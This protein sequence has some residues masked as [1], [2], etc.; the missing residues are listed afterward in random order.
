MIL[1][2]DKFD[3]LVQ[4]LIGLEVTRVWRGFGTALFIELGKLSKKSYRLKNGK[5]NSFLVGQYSIFIG[6][7]W[8]VE[9]SKS[10]YFGSDSTEK[11]I[12]KRYSQLNGK[13][14]TAVYYEGRLPE[15]VVELSD[16]LWIH[17]F[18]IPSTSDTQPTWY[19]DLRSKKPRQ[20]I[21]SHLGKLRI[22]NPND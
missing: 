9:H 19:I 1:P 20:F 13:F 10:I 15:L 11:C 12:S 14:V 6:W 16:R 4:P 7:D 21:R 17:S 22:N 2:K 8:R 5:W 3:K 18:Q